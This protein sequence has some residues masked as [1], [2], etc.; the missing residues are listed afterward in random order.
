MH[1][2]L[3]TGPSFA[4]T[5]CAPGGVILGGKFLLSREMLGWGWGGARLVLSAGDDPEGWGSDLSVHYS[6]HPGSQEKTNH[7]LGGRPP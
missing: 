7:I 3:E 4:R 2:S 6:I 5:L 1:L